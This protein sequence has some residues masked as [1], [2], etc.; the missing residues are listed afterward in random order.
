MLEDEQANLDIVKKDLLPLVIC[1]CWVDMI[2][3]LAKVMI[4]RECARGI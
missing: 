3:Y 4:T 2:T 1:G